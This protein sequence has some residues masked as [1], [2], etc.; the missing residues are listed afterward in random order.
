MKK[1]IAVLCFALFVM[2]VLA[3]TEQQDKTKACK[4]AATNKG[5]KGDKRQAYVKS[6]VS[7]KA[8]KKPETTATPK[9]KDARP[10]TA[11]ARAPATAAPAQPS[12][13]APA[14]PADPPTQSA[15]SASEKKRLRCDEIAR[16][17]NVSPSSSKDFMAKCMAG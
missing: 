9:K 8:K 16:Q 13:G 10:A 6:C 17:S 2:P 1:I 14:I 4:A 7:A 3:A 15:N 12:A 11:A 5:L